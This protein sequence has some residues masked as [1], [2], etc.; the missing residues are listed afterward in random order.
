MNRSA[1]AQRC[2][3]AVNSSGGGKLT[4]DLLF[5]GGSRK[6]YKSQLQAQRDY[7][8]DE[9]EHSGGGGMKQEEDRDRENDFYTRN[10][11][12]YDENPENSHVEYTEDWS[13]K[14]VS[15]SLTGG[16]DHTQKNYAEFESLSVRHLRR[17]LLTPSPREK[18]KRKTNMKGARGRGHRGHHGTHNHP[19]PH[20]Q[21]SHIEENLHGLGLLQ[22]PIST[23][24][25]ATSYFTE[26]HTGG[27]NT[28]GGGG[29]QSEEMNNGGTHDQQQ[30]VIE[31][32]RAPKRGE[33]ASKKCDKDSGS[34]VSFDIGGIFREFHQ[35]T[36]S[37]GTGSSS[38]SAN[39]ASTADPSSSSGEEIQGS[40]PN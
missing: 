19:T 40:H 31:S 29:A 14:F 21:A 9:R 37:E 39:P 22:F 15:E 36:T 10:T 32:P 28:E 7:E 30:H 6:A 23:R 16:G 25:A 4:R 34:D 5:Q 12:R 11:E 27:H 17:R 8:N 24:F 38:S 3:N 2:T 20:H 35:I 1:F 13:E 33:K 26:P 18:A